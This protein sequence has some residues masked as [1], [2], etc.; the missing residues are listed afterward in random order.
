MIRWKRNKNDI[1]MFWD[2]FCYL[3]KSMGT[4]PNAVCKE[5]GFS[6]ATS[7]HW[8][9][10]TIPNGNAIITIADYFNC[11][12]DYLLGCV[13]EPKATFKNIHTSNILN[14]NGNNGDNFTLT[15]NR[16]LDENKELLEL[17][18]SLSLKQK[19]KIITFIYDMMEAEH[20]E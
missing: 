17:I 12:T 3:C 11:S 7:T 20:Y 1:N 4:T 13:T 18:Q 2:N 16:A 6:G 8:K 19:A 15:V 9:N 10:G 5:L 14:V